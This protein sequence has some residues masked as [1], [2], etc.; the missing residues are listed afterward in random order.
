MTFH[1]RRFPQTGEVKTVAS[2]RF[3]CARPL[4]LKP[5][6]IAISL[7]IAKMVF[8]AGN[9]HF[10]AFLKLKNTILGKIQ[11]FYFIFS[12]VSLQSYSLKV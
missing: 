4:F 9:S 7:T 1:S 10:M 5:L 3:F 6:D 8:H 11:N 12:P 2:V